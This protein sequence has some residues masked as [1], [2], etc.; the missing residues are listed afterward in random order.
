[1]TKCL[2]MILYPTAS[3]E[4]QPKEISKSTFAYNSFF[5]LFSAKTK[6]EISFIQY[7]C[8]ILDFPSLQNYYRLTFL[9]KLINNNVIRKT[10]PFDKSEFD[11]LHN[12][13]TKYNL[14]AGTD[15]FSIKKGIWSYISK[16][17]DI[18]HIVNNG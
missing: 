15:K 17:F 5:K 18:D 4:G 9:N 3:A 12:L 14:T 8:N 2:P 11:E 6:N 10:N 1:M 13:N 7:H 16:S